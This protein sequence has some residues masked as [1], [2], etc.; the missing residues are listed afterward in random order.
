MFNNKFILIL[1]S[2]I[3]IIV[4][5]YLFSYYLKFNNEKNVSK[6]AIMAIFKDEEQYIEEWLNYHINQGISHFYLYCNDP[7]I[8]KYNFEPYKNYVTLINWTDK[9]NNGSHTI[10][11]QAYYDCV[12]NYSKNHDFIMM[13]D[14]DEFLV[15][16]QKDKTVIDFLNTIDKNNTKALKIPRYNFGSNGHKTKPKGGVIKNYNMRENICSSYKTIANTEYIDT[17]KMFY[18]VHDFNFINKNGKIYNDN[19]SYIY[20]G[21][22]NGCTNETINE[23]QLVINHYYTKSFEEYI[24]RC[25]LWINGGVNTIGFRKNCETEFNE[26][27]YNQIEDNIINN[28]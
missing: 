2:M 14:I 28:K 17:T 26:K 3:F 6:F 24:K 22:P 4:I 19:F 10:Q 7:N 8:S 12:N 20:T 16:N 27:N 5:S 25:N 21:F 23:T 11:R 1:I 13:L 18:G 15:N 9:I